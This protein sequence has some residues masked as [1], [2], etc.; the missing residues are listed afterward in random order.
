MAK[1]LR[2]FSPNAWLVVILTALCLFPV[3]CGDT[4]QTFDE[5]STAPQVIIEPSSLSL[6]V[7]SV[8]GTDIICQGRGFD[9]KERVFVQIKIKDAGGDDFEIGLCSGDTDDKGNFEAPVES[10]NKVF[11][12]L[13]ASL[14]P[15]KENLA[16][17]V[18]GPPIQAGEY[19]V[20]VEGLTSRKKA[21]TQIAMTE[22]GIIDSIKDWLGVKTGKIIKE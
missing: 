7:A 11:S 22:P 12:L 5:T 9:P 18:S 10:A 20:M 8:M 15:T 4:P 3:A 1:N 13:N 19:D 14:E 6:S 2:G 17:K 21:T 16:L